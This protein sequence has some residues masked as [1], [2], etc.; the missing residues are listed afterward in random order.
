MSSTE[1]SFQ[2]SGDILDSATLLQLVDLDDGAYGLLEEMF[3]IFRD[4]TLPRIQALDEAI[5]AGN[6][7]AMGDVAHAI[8]GASATMGAPRV[9][10]VAL[11]LETAGRKGIGDVKPPEL[12]AALQIEFQNAVEALQSYIEA[13]R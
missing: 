2:P 1:S 6:L 10:A 5:Q 12:F 8:K 4:D 3:Q 9:R 13:N 7:E 11:A